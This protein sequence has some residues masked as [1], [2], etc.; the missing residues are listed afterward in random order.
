VTDD[1]SPQREAVL[2]GHFAEILALAVEI[3]GVGNILLRIVPSIAGKD[4]I[5][6]DRYKPK[7]EFTCKL[8]KAMWKNRVDRESRDHVLRVGQL[9]DNSD[10][11]YDN[12]W[13]CSFN[14]ATNRDFILGSN[15]GDEIIFWNRLQRWMIDYG[16]TERSVD[17]VVRGQD[18]Y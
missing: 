1:R 16:I 8:R 10:R 17:V 18:L 5:G 15:S 11:V 12:I 2:R 3:D 9:L 6:T 14:R 4:T 7:S 13:T